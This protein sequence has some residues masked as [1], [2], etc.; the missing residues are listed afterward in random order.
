MRGNTY[1]SRTVGTVLYDL[2]ISTASLVP[3]A[4][5]N[6]C[7]LVP[8]SNAT[9]AALAQLELHGTFLCHTLNQDSFVV[10]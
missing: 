5:L 8:W 6:A 1:K 3:L 7:I 2:L 9:P 4:V 10:L